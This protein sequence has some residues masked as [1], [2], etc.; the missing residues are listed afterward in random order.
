M[1]K[2]TPA[3]VS[4]SDRLRDMGLSIKKRNRSIVYIALRSYTISVTESKRHTGFFELEDELNGVLYTLMDAEEV[5]RYIKGVSEQEKSK[6][7]KDGVFAAK[8]KH[9]AEIHAMYKEK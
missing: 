8:K 9:D 7:Y 3:M 2:F 1:D 5:C 6:A 4:L